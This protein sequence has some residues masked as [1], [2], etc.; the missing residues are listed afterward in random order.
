[1]TVIV[2]FISS[3]ER[4]GMRRG[5]GTFG[6]VKLAIEEEKPIYISLGRT[7]IG[8][9]AI[10]VDKALKKPFTAA[11]IYIVLIELSCCSFLEYPIEQ[12]KAF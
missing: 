7:V 2:S 8:Y 6:K 5:L 11:N 12:D 1:M 9:S 3:K 4:N 10:V